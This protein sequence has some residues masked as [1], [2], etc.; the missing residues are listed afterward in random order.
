VGLVVQAPQALHDRFLHLVEPFGRLAGL[1][2]D[3]QDRVVVKLNL[4][5]ARPAAITAQPGG[6]VPVELAHPLLCSA[7]GGSPCA[8]FAQ[9]VT[10]SS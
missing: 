4:E 5:I 3:L 8:C 10:S 1:G 7:S 2:V 9:P 6:A